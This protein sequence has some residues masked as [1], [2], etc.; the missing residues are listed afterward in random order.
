MTRNRKPLYQLV[1]S[2]ILWERRVAVLATFYFI[3][4]NQFAD[5]LKIGEILLNTIDNNHSLI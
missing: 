4:Y 5:A 2:K 1:K 3:K